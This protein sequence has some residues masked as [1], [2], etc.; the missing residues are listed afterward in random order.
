M[1]TSPYMTFRRLR[2]TKFWVDALQE[3]IIFLNR[4]TTSESLFGQEAFS[5]SLAGLP[6]AADL[7]RAMDN[8]RDGALTVDEAQST[9][10]FPK[11]SKP[12]SGHTD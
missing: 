6:A 4:F 2:F 8:I 3:S 11:Y 9:Y 10:L 1:A 7:G 12:T 5:F